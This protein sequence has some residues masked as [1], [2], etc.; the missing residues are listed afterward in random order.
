MDHGTLTDNNGRKTDFRNIILIMTTNAGAESLDRTSIGFAK[1]DHSSDAMADIKK[2]FTP[3]FRNRLDTIV[4]FGS[5]P[6]NIIATVVDK[7]LVK[8]QNQLD[9]KKVFL[10]VDDNARNWLAT[11]GYDAKMGARPM[12][13]LIQDKIKKPLADEVLFG[14]LSQRGGTVSVTVKNNALDISIES[15]ELTEA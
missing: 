12:D 6:L 13:R 10:K 5:L 15:M 2:T 7:F 4:Q 3:E 1:Q 9:E 11:N 14:T 8:L